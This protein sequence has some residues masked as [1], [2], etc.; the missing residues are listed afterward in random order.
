M[1]KVLVLCYHALSPDW[2]APLSTTPEAFERQIEFLIRSGWHS[3]TFSRAVATPPARPTVVVTFDDAFRSV[4]RYAAPVLERFDVAATMF[5]PTHYM[6]SGER[7]GW[8]GV[9]HWQQTPHAAELTPMSWDDLRGLSDRGWEIGSHTRTHPH[10]TEL[11]AGA[12]ADE[13]ERSRA[14][15]AEAMGRP[16]LSIAY[17]YGDV[18][19]AVAAAAGRAGYAAGAALSSSLTQLGPLRWPRVGIYNRD[20]FGRFRLKVAGPMRAL[21]ASPVWTRLHG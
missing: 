6:T 18:D 21:R 1:S 5:A 20:T 10:L 7:F 16:C 15:C 19:A 12:V 9:A 17:P 13:L 14:E 3:D 2:E 8:D 11:D 4:L